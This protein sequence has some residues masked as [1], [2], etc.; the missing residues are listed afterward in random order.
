MNATHS[1]LALIAI[2]LGAMGGIASAMGDNT[3]VKETVAFAGTAQ[4]NNMCAVMA[5][6]QKDAAARRAALDS[7]GCK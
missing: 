7:I 2:V 6:L 1:K 4:A 3:P 5:S